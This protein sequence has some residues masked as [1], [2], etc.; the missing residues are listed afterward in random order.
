MTCPLSDA[1][2]QS[3]LFLKG[4]DT[5]RLK[6]LSVLGEQGIVRQKQKK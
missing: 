3:G 1:G 4:Q 2:A 5:V 6:R